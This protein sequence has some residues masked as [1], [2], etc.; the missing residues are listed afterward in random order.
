MSKHPAIAAI[1][2]KP[3]QA[4]AIVT[5][6]VDRFMKRFHLEVRVPY[7]ERSGN[8]SISLVNGSVL[9]VVREDHPECMRGLKFDSVFVEERRIWES[10][11]VQ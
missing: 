6:N 5:R 3:G 7:T 9:Y 10:L 1:E 2:D 11:N 8:H 4:V